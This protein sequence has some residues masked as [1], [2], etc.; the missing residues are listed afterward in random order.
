MLLNGNLNMEI[1]IFGYLIFIIIIFIVSL[2]LFKKL[3]K[4]KYS[5][6]MNRLSKEERIVF[7]KILDTNG[8]T[9]QADLIRDTGFSKVRIIRIL[10]RLQSR[11]LIERKRRGMSNIVFLNKL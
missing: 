7:E 6:I 9:Y 2:I 4:K 1:R 5:K 10:R 8:P 3:C 11:D